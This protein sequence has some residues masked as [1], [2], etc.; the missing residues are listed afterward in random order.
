MFFG[1]LYSGRR[2]AVKWFNKDTVSS[3]NSHRCFLNELRT[4]ARIKHKNIA[5]LVGYCLE[6]P[7]RILVYD[8]MSNGTLRQHLDN[9]QSPYLMSWVN[10][11]K[12]ALGVARAVEY[13]HFYAVPPIIHRD[14]KTSNV[15]FDDEWTAKLL[16]LGDS[17]EVG[18]W[19]DQPVAGTYGYID[20]EYMLSGK[21]TTSSDVYSFGVVLLELLTG[22]KSFDR[23]AD[24]NYCSLVDLAMWKTENGHFMNGLDRKLPPPSSSF[25]VD[26]IR[27][28]FE[29]AT[30]CLRRKVKNRPSMI[31]VVRRLDDALAI[32]ETGAP[33]QEITQTDSDSDYSWGSLSMFHV[34]PG[35]ESDEAGSGRPSLSVASS[36]QEDISRD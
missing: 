20:P 16:D 7:A 12:A 17:V 9:E 14:I 34:S 25:E 6:G 23:D 32:S 19:D 26:A 18:E 35:H 4:Q 15:L 36:W 33:R 1:E 11:M 2:V 24:G 28:V 30:A 5:T 13:L 10:R 3:Q 31:E 21:W 8:Y 27:D 22:Q 29:L